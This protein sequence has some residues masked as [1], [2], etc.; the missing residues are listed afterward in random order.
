MCVSTGEDGAN[1]R[2]GDGL[3]HLEEWR[4]EIKNNYNF[5]LIK[6]KFI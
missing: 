4:G 6:I 2:G 1:G 3:D 5:F